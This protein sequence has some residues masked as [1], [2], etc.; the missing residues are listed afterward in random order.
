MV[1]ERRGL[2]NGCESGSTEP[3]LGPSALSA[4]PAGRLL[5]PM[6]VALRRPSRSRVAA[7][8]ARGRVPRRACAARPT[9]AS[10]RRP[11]GSPASWAS[12]AELAA[13][14]RSPTSCS[15][16]RSPRSRRCRGSTRRWRARARTAGA[17]RGA[18]ASPTRRRSAS[19]LQTPPSTN[20]RAIEVVYRYRLDDADEVSA[21]PRA[22]M[23]VPL[24]AGD[25][26]LGSL[27]ALSRSS[28][29]RFSDETVDALEGIARRA[30]PALV[31]AQALHRGAAARRPRLAHRPLQPPL[32]HERSSARWPAPAA[33]SGGSRWSCST[34]TTSSAI[35]D[36]ARPPRRRRGARRGRPAHPLA[37][38]AR[39][40]SRAGSAATSSR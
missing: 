19:P 26:P 11:G 24:R 34:S 12:R 39:P 22:G 2:V 32:F 3:F 9:S 38:S 14:A 29:H 30:G 35:N 23:V 25:Q 17:A 27:A 36:T 16:T 40:T 15:S 13:L 6:T 8:V 37:S 7:V 20:L 10:P 18:R 33:T 31:T 28:A 5:A 21:R 1:A 4:D